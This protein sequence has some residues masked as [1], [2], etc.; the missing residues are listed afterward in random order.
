[1]LAGWGK[2]GSCEGKG[3]ECCSAA[4]ERFLRLSLIHRFAG[5]RVHPWKNPL[6]SSWLFYHCDRNLYATILE[7]F[8]AVVI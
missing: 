4:D 5:N 7:I 2:V 6:C 1:M 8:Q 3:Q